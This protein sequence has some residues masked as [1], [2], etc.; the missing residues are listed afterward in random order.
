M[1][2]AYLSQLSISLNSKESTVVDLSIK[3][4]SPKKAE[5]ILNTLITVYNEQWVQDRNLVAESTSQFI[6]E[7]LAVIEADLGHV[8]NNISSYKS[9][10]FA[11]RRTAG[12]EHVYDAGSE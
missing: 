1:A 7:R 8:D 10:N 9:R 12:F 2:D 4:E 6:S 5:D 3:D 11:A